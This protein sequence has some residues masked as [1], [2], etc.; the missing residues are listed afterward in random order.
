MGE[1]GNRELGLQQGM[2]GLWTKLEFDAVKKRESDIGLK[3]VT[4]D[5]QG[6]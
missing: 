2:E 3:C 4:V 1:M 6:R 5:D